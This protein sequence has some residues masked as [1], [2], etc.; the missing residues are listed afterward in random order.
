M[1][2]EET[3]LGDGTTAPWLSRH[4]QRPQQTDRQT[5]KRRF[6]ELG[7]PG[8]EAL[9]CLGCIGHLCREDGRGRSDGGLTPSN[10]RTLLITQ[11]VAMF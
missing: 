10:S 1:Q 5:S 9:Q 2:N 6:G 3:G 11:P 4:T 8:P 7:G